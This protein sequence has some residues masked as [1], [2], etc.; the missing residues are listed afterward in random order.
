MLCKVGD[1]YSDWRR[2]VIVCSLPGVG[3]RIMEQ[4]TLSGELFLAART[5]APR[6][7]S[8]RDLYSALAPIAVVPAAGGDVTVCPGR[9][10][11]MTRGDKVTLVGTPAKLRAATVADHPERTVASDTPRTARRTS[12]AGHLRHLAV[13]LARAA[14]RGLAGALGAVLAVLVAATIVLRLTC[15]YA[16]PGHRISLL[17]AA[18]FTVK[19]VTTGGTATTPSAASR[20]G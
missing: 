17:D 11:R 2:H 14:N 3:L 10:T 4:L 6:T 5:T 15:T 12:R 13:S 16:G 7:S 9:D 19:T 1:A 8:L 18:Y 20:H